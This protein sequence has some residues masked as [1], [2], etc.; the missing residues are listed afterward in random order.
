MSTTVT[1]GTFPPGKQYGFYFDQGRCDGCNT[2]MLACQEWNGLPIGAAGRWMRCYTWEEGAFPNVR[3]YSVVAPCYH[4]ENP[5]CVDAANGALYK[6]PKYG[7]VLMDPEKA[8]TQGLDLRAAYLACPY[9]AILFDSDGADA[10][11]SKCTM[12]IDR[13]EQ[14]LAPICVTSCDK[15][16]LE[17]GPLADLQQKFGTLRQLKGMPDPS[18]AQPALVV[19]AQL[20][21]KQIVPYDANKALELWQQ[22]GQMTYTGSEFSADAP[23]VFEN[24]SDLTDPMP[25]RVF[26]NKLVMHHK[27]NAELL[28]YTQPDE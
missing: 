24:K 18:T 16:A 27:T 12:C 14:G 3:L 5:V 22:R 23:L 9:G 8:K 10:T 21:K 7:A 17:F 20:P 26:K 6:E 11:A 25:D 28:Y 19:K 2:C 4:C 1:T 15:R 13:L